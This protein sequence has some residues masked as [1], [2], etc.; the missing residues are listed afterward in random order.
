MSRPSI[1]RCTAEAHRWLE[2]R[3]VDSYHWYTPDGV[4]L[5]RALAADPTITPVQTEGIRDVGEDM[6]PAHGWR[7]PDGSLIVSVESFLDATGTD[8]RDGS[9][10]VQW[11]VV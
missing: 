7:F 9:G 6:G 8:G 3:G 5:E 1:D 2:A 11:Q 4:H 10:E